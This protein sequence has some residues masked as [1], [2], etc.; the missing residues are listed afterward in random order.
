MRLRFFIII[1]A[2]ILI[3][4]ILSGCTWFSGEDDEYGEKFSASDL[5]APDVP[6]YDPHEIVQK[7]QVNDSQ[8]PP[9]FAY[10]I[11]WAMGEVYSDWGSFIRITIENTGA[12]DLFIYRCGIA[13][14]WTFPSQWFLEER[15]IPIPKNE[16][17]A[18]GIVYFVA[19]KVSGDFTYN[20]LISIL[21]KDNELFDLFGVESWYDNG[22]IQGKDKEFTVTALDPVTETKVVHNYKHYQDKLKKRIEFDNSNIVSTTNDVISD[23]PG[24]YNIYQVLAIFDF[25]VDSLTYISDPDGRDYW[26]YC[27]ETLIREGGDCEDFSIL[28]SS[29]VGSLGGITRIYLTNTHAF[30]AVYIGAESQK[31]AIVDAIIKYYGTIPNFVIFQEEGKY[32][33]AAD[34]GGSLYMGGLPADA[35]PAYVSE[36]PLIFGFIFKDTKEIHVIDI[37]E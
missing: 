20:I 27:W 37:I 16:E 13:V 10:N 32:W 30:P 1:V 8:L 33:L 28:F 25:M 22:T 24:S 31:N 26:A 18:L 34:P 23:Y 36:I 3:T 14:N 15:N 5:I 17:K 6:S 35:K 9:G 11:T 4:P 21:V 29:M 12:N 2:L 19:P 7:P